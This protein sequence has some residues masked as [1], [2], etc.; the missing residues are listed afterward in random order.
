[1]VDMKQL[2]TDMGD[3]EEDAVIEALEQVMDEGGIQAQEALKACQD[4]MSI[5]G[6]RFEEGEYFVSDLIFAGDL[7]TEAVEMLKDALV[8]DEDAESD[9]RMIL[10]TVKGDLHDIGKNVVRAMLEASGFSVIDLGIDV[11]AD[12]IIDTMREQDIHIV[13]L[14]G[15]LTMAVDSMKNIVE[16]IEKAGLRDSSKIIIGGTPTSQEACEFVGADDWAFSPQKTVEVCSKWAS[17]LA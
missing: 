17:Q 1:M 12:K 6:D 10:C 8:G 2:C 3:L 13:G 11:P 7:M 5:I 15:V 16:E 9:A 14:S 4:G